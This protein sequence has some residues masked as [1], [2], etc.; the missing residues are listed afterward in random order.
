L[1]WAFSGPHLSKPTNPLI[2]EAFHRTGAVETWG[3]STNRVIEMC[4]KHGAVPPVFEE[5]QGFLIVAFKAR[6]VAGRAA[7]IARRL[8]PLESRL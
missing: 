1:Q 3:R 4:R 2:A 7:P 6:M 8:R 5:R